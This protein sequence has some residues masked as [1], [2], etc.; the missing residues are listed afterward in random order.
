MFLKVDLFYFFIV[1][2]VLFFVGL[3][4]IIIS[5][6]SIIQILISIELM[7]LAININFLFFS[8]FLDDV[9]GFIFAFY[10]LAVAAAEASI[11]LALLVV[12][13]RIQGTISIR[14]ITLL[15]G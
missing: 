7:L 5:R 9:K 12:Y 15:Q 2:T 10:I 4:G 13:F 6:R 14:S 1:S 3:F 8:V 11:G